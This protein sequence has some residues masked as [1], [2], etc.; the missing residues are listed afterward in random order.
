MKLDFQKIALTP[1]ILGGILYYN[2]WY[3]SRE[4][5]YGRVG[6]LRVFKKQTL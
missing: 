4:L 1:F 5:G 2:R 6:A 3:H